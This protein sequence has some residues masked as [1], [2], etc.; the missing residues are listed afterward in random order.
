MSDT[1]NTADLAVQ[2]Q[3]ALSAAMLDANHIQKLKSVVGGE[4]GTNGKSSVHADTPLSDYAVKIWQG[5][6]VYK[7][8]SIVSNFNSS[9]RSDQYYYYEPAYFLV[10][11]VRIRAEGQEAASAKYGVKRKNYAVDVYALKQP[12]TDEEV[13][14]RDPALGGAFEDA[15]AFITRQ[16]LMNKEAKLASALLAEG[17]WATDWT[18]ITTA[19][20]TGDKVMAGGEFQQFDEETCN[21]LDVLDL[22]FETIQ[23][24]SG[25]RPNTVV[26]QRQI[27]TALKRNAIIKTTTLYT[28]TDSGTTS[29][30]LSTIAS[31][32]DIDVSR[33]FVLD[34]VQA[35]AGAVIDGTSFE[36]TTDEEG[37]ASATEGDATSDTIA[38]EFIGGKSVLCMHVDMKT[39]GQ[40]SA[41]AAV[42]CQWTSLYPDAG[43]LGNTVFKRYRLEQYSAEFVEGR[44]AFRYVIVAPALGLLLTNVIK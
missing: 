44:T 21:P 19:I 3:A 8:S 30:V 38:N 41:T 37:Y 27:F 24:K 40:Y 31:H 5:D 43:S 2:I 22:A 34:A 35:E 32:L 26:L 20:T 16:F 36:I 15:T 7:A 1:L 14:N 28:T 11:Q 23:R 13:Q 17:V 29:S 39:N 25:K 33:I 18:G 4:P 6:D 12:V 42:C 9:F 10:N